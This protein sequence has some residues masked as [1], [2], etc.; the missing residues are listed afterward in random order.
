[1]LRFF[2]RFIFLLL[3]AVL[4]LSCSLIDFLSG[5]PRSTQTVPP[6]TQ[7]PLETQALN[8]PTLPLIV[9][10]TVNRTT[11]AALTPPVLPESTLD[12]FP[13]GEIYFSASGEGMLRLEPASRELVQMPLPGDAAFPFVSPDGNRLGF[14]FSQDQAGG[15]SHYFGVSEAGQVY[16][17][18]S[19]SPG[20]S[21][22]PQPYLAA[23]SPDGELVASVSALGSEALS[24][25]YY[26]QVFAFDAQAAPDL[27]QLRTSFQVKGL[28]DLVWAPDSRGLAWI[29][30]SDSGQ[31][32]FFAPLSES[33]LPAGVEQTVQMLLPQETALAVQALPGSRL[34]Y[35]AATGIYLQ[36]NWSENPRLITHNLA[37]YTRAAFDP[38]GR[39]AG[40]YSENRGGLFVL[41]L[42]SGVERLV[43]EVP[44]GEF[45]QVLAWDARG[46]YLAF[47]LLNVLL[48]GYDYLYAAPLEGEINFLR[49][50]PHLSL[51]LKAR[52]LVAWHPSEPY[53][54]FLERFEAGYIIWL[55]AADGSGSVE[56][57]PETPGVEAVFSWQAEPAAIDLVQLPLAPEPC[58]AVA[59][60]LK[61]GN[62]AYSNLEPPII[63]LIYRDAGFSAP[64]L[65]SLNP[66]EPAWVLG[67]PI[68][69][70]NSNFWLLRAKESSLVGWA[71]E[72][73]S[74][75]Y[76]LAPRPDALL[77]TVS[78]K[79]YALPL[80]VPELRLVADPEGIAPGAGMQ[81]VSP[82]WLPDGQSFSYL[83]S[84]P[85]LAVGLYIQTY[86]DG[87]GLDLLS[88]LAQFRYDLPAG[89]WSPDGSRVVIS[90][91]PEGGNRDLF[92]IQ[93]DGSLI[94]NLTGPSL[95]DRS[96][97]W[98]PDGTRIVFLSGQGAATE[99]HV[100]APGESITR[101]TNNQVEEASPAWSPLG[102]RIAFAE[103]RD[104]RP[105]LFTITFPGGERTRLGTEPGWYPAWSPDGQRI[106]FTDPVND[107]LLLVNADGTNLRVLALAGDDQD[108]VQVVWAPSGDRL[109]Y[110]YQ[111]TVH[112]FDL[113]TNTTQPVATGL[114]NP[115]I[116]WQ[117]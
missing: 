18:S 117:P 80:D 65:G 62:S 67:G 110:V 28:A 70:A 11:P 78:R 13:A 108:P 21:L 61:I 51:D 87:A 41:D 88:M 31:R 91:G 16:L 85:K 81:L 14:V 42:L 26:I 36:A 82:H 105:E 25:S 30:A 50:I 77:I 5:E 44:A 97:A 29:A 66:G 48:P 19:K 40:I 106:A 10:P 100:L 93:S 102:S 55:A 4:L 79:L 57:N 20:R 76:F 1:M 111:N 59:P 115:W 101:L 94:Q 47:S 69:S 24:T 116:A 22:S 103:L 74:A 64:V 63:S 15:S 37:P 46:R 7:S 49:A 3:A 58:T 33:P 72:G 98:S 52:S 114:D 90:L 83:A 38:S 99:M 8:T 45:G 12:H 92:L 53:I 73:D 112:I 89:A 35:A 86:P 27:W 32:F 60:R 113:T 2:Q 56:L 54:S 95:D 96:P 109:A 6:S 17:P 71:A 75:S 68:C 107:R 43:S 9:V 104:G 84:A 39:W 23:W 34:I